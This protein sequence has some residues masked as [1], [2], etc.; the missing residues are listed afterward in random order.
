MGIFDSMLR[1]GQTIFRDSIALDYDYI[2]KLVPFRETQQ[3]YVATCIKPLFA[4][5]N[6]KNLI[7]HGPPGVGK[8]VAVRH[9]LKELEDTTEEILPI[10]INCWQKNTT[11]KVL[12]A[13]CE[14]IGYAF[15]QNKKTEDLFNIVEKELNKKSVVFVFDEIDKAEENDFLY[16]ILEKIYRKTIIIITNHKEWFITLDDRIKSRLTPEFLEFKEYNAQET[17]GILK[18]RSEYAFVTGSFQEDAF[19]LATKKASE[20]QD[21][22]KG[23][24]I[25]RE[26]ANLAEAESKKKVTPEHVKKAIDKLE[27]FTIKKTEDLDEDDKLILSVIKNNSG[28]KI[29]EL[30]EVYQKNGGTGVYKTF[31]RRVKKL[32]TSKFISVKKVS[33]GLDGRT[34]IVSKVNNKKLTEY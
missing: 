1:D 13:I 3:R 20:L 9:L 23:L 22:R 32:E 26:A 28:K 16:S 30:F 15:T 12:L 6:G 10:Y 27:E 33:G 17:R 11:F 34:S 14:E 29:G 4:K 8:T 24:Y 19:E 2:P 5:R 21:V 7:L 18:Q 31:Q 25:L